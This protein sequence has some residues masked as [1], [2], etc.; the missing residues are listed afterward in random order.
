[1]PLQ[2]A[3]SLAV[4]ECINEGILSEFLRKSKAEVI[5]MSIFEYDEELHERTLREEGI[6]IGR[7]QGLEQGIMETITILKNMGHSDMQII[8]LLIDTYGLTEADATD[9]FNSATE[10]N[11]EKNNIYHTTVFKI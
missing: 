3:V 1:M 8:K 5:R 6:S 2:E 7:E 10:E 9:L 11:T 4:D